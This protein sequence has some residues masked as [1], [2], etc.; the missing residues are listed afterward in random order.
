M[1][2]LTKLSKQV[3]LLLSQVESHRL[4]MNDL[5][6]GSDVDFAV[7]S[8]S[9]AEEFRL[10]INSTIEACWKSTELFPALPQQI[11]KVAKRTLK[12][13]AQ[14]TMGLY[15]PVSR[16]VETV[17][18]ASALWPDTSTDKGSKPAPKSD[19]YISSGLRAR[20]RDDLAQKASE[21]LGHLDELLLQ[22]DSG[23]EAPGLHDAVKHMKAAI[24]TLGSEISAALDV[25]IMSN[26]RYSLL[27]LAEKELKRLDERATLEESDKRLLDK[28]KEVRVL[29]LSSKYEEALQAAKRTTDIEEL[30]RAVTLV[31]SATARQEDAM[32][33]ASRRLALY[34]DYVPPM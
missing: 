34:P 27:A 4:L 17:G 12:N 22:L 31:R 29:Q 6:E 15:E 26:V 14:G 33:A 25:N 20:L 13:M 28:H 1:D 30:V 32:Y 8:Y 5:L 24:T 7:R 10:K 9:E 2:K 19:E 3:A 21:T 11:S 18:Q 23:P 16:D